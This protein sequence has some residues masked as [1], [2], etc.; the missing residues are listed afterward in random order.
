MLDSML[1]SRV[2]LRQ[3]S[4]RGCDSRYTSEQRKVA[5][6]IQFITRNLAGNT[7]TRTEHVVGIPDR[8]RIHSIDAGAH[9]SHLTLLPSLVRCQ[10]KNMDST[11]FQL[12]ITATRHMADTTST[13]EMMPLHTA[14]P[15]TQHAS[16]PRRRCTDWCQDCWAHH[17]LSAMAAQDETSS[18]CMP[19]LKG[20]SSDSSAI[21]MSRK[22]SIS[23]AKGLK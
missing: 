9:H 14:Q 17:T 1:S 12:I 3:L 21:G 7:G 16:L 18:A 5:E 10:S 15:S 23:A 19:A 13:A 20:D 22:C 8:Q 6:H 11:S 2:W 4:S